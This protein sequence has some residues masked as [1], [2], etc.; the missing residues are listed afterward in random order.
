M[1]NFRINE[2][3]YSIN[4]FGIWHIMRKSSAIDKDNYVYKGWKRGKGR[5]EKKM[6]G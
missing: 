2:H 4:S 6:D 5:Q 1:Y 3:A